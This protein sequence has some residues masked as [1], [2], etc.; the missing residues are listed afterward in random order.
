MS[1]SS[2]SREVGDGAMCERA[3]AGPMPA[4][5]ALSER[6][7][8]LGFFALASGGDVEFDALTLGE[9]LVAVTLDC[10]EVDEH[11]VAT[12]TSDEA[13]ALLA[14]EPLHGALCHV[15]L[16]LR[17]PDVHRRQRAGIVAP[18]SCGL[19]CDFRNTRTLVSQG[20]E[21][22]GTLARNAERQRNTRHTVKAT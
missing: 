15:L 13:V 21:I 4:E 17:A 8:V 20:E 5:G 18:R 7:D 14:V 10:G 19:D 3:P 1:A 16:P 11:V 12:L 9:A 6:T 22:P 2:Q